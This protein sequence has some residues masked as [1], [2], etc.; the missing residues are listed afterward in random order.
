MTIAERIVK[1]WKVSKDDDIHKSCKAESSLMSE[2]E[3]PRNDYEAQVYV[4]EDGSSIIVHPHGV[5]ACD[6]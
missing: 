4:F 6:P 1:E 5:E 3:V 2:Y